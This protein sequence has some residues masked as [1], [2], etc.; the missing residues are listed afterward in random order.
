MRAKISLTEDD[1]HAAIAAHISSQLGIDI[2]TKDIK[3]EVK[4]KQNYRSE[5]EVAAIRAEFEAPP[6]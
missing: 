6:R 3:V 2:S 1:I 5:W 4:S